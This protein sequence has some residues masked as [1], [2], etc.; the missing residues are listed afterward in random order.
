VE[1]FACGLCLDFFK[2]K[3]ELQVGEI[4]NMYAIIEKLTES[5][6]QRI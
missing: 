6:L 5:K 2:L 3:D 4:T 1:L